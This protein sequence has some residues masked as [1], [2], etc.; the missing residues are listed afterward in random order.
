MICHLNVQDKVRE[1]I[2]SVIGKKRQPRLADKSQMPYTEATI[3]EI[4]RMANIS[5]FAL[6]HSTLYKGIALRGKFIPRSKL[7]F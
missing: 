2:Y 6:P 4:H 1:E 3:L 7:S 5:T